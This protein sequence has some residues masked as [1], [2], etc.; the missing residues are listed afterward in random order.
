MKA[1]LVFFLLFVSFAIN[2][3]ITVKGVIL[4]EKNQPIPY[5]NI[6]V[7]KTTLGTSSDFDGNFKITLKKNKGKLQISLLGFKTVFKKVSKKTTFIK[8]ILKEEASQLNE[9]II[10]T[11]PKKRL[12]KKCRHHFK[13]FSW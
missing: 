5:A 4:D 13:I 11:K 12:S 9:I 1:S 8:I 10:V 6:I 3:Q 2:A 7:H